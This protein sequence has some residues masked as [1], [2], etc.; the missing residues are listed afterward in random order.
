MTTVITEGDF[1]FEFDDTWIPVRYDQHRDYVKKIGTLPQTKAVDIIAVRRSSGRPLFF[2][3]ITDLRGWRVANK[4]HLASGELAIEVA[5]KVRDTVAGL[6][7]AWRNSSDLESWR[8]S[9][10]AL[11]DRN[12]RIQV[13]LFL[14]QDLPQTPRERRFSQQD[15]LT[16]QIKGRLRWLTTKVLVTSQ[17]R[18]HDLPG[19]FVRHRPKNGKR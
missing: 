18:K 10:D 8:Q 3:E 1:S 16:Q 11:F 9:G 17:S 2:I 6:V 7:G 15:V 13:V 14:E 5:Q 19:V 12:R 4:D